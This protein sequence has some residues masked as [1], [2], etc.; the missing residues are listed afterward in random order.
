MTCGCNERHNPAMTTG[1]DLRLERTAA[2]VR[3]GVLAARMGRHPATVN[4]WEGAA[5][6]PDDRAQAYRAAL[7]NIASDATSATSAT[8]AA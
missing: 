7:A 6:V 3:L 4:R 1:M 2:R 5:V 8:A